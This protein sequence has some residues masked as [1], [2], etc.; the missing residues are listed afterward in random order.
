M[1]HKKGRRLALYVWD[2]NPVRI[3]LALRRR[4]FDVRVDGRHIIFET[5]AY[6]Y[7]VNHAL[8]RYMLNAG[9]TVSYSLVRL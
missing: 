4:G 2:G 3:A 6:P 1:T 7:A 8:R 5:P 9:R